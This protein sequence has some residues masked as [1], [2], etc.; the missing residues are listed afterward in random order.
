M[1]SLKYSG[2]EIR[3]ATTAPTATIMI[4]VKIKNKSN[5]KNKN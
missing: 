3:P 4:S 2:K 1:N 5:N